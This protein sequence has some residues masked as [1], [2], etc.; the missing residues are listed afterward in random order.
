MDKSLEE[1]MKPYFDKKEE[2]ENLSSQKNVEIRTLELRL[3]KLK[4]NRQ[5]EIDDYIQEASKTDLNFYAGYTASLRKSLEAAYDEKENSIITEIEKLKN[6]SDYSRVYI[7]EMIELKD[8]L[9]KELVAKKKDLNI[10][11][12]KANIEFQKANL[13]LSSFKYEYNSERQ[14]LNGDKWKGLY[15]KF[16]LATSLIQEIKKELEMIDDYLRVTELTE[17]EIKVGMMA[18]TPWEKEEYDRRKFA[19]NDDISQLEKQENIDESDVVED[20]FTEDE[21]ILDIEP[22]NDTEEEN[23]ESKDEDLIIPEEE[24]EDE[25]SEIDDFYIS[26]EENNESSNDLPQDAVDSYVPVEGSYSFEDGK[27]ITESYNELTSLIFNDVVDMATKLDYVKLDPSSNPKLK[28]TKYFSDK[29][30]QGSYN[31]RSSIETADVQGNEVSLPNGEYVNSKDIMRA[32]DEY[33][34]KNKGQRF[35]VKEKNKTISLSKF[36]ILKLKKAVKN[37][38][39]LK[40]V[41][42]GKLSEFDVKKVYG[43]ENFEKMKNSVEVGEVNTPI[44]EGTYI[45]RDELLYELKRILTSKNK[46]IEWLRKISDKFKFLKEQKNSKEIENSDENFELEDVEIPNLEF[47]LDDV[48][49]SSK[50]M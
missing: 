44:S 31:Y 45:S 33:Y 36:D 28:G 38:S 47:D 37:C 19:I 27:V 49:E 12:I 21:N 5:R 35:Y 18:M 15:N 10:E 6:K 41:E 40:L 11:L 13:E 29:E 43:K 32:V 42:D 17:E 50:T 8:K 7:R 24:K 2:I 14:V 20:N 46:K 4:D 26:G 3:E 16:S 9:R 30:L 34:N 48:E 39:A 1:L 25:N 22:E 23:I